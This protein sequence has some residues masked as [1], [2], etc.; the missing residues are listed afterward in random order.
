MPQLFLRRQFLI[1]FLITFIVFGFLLNFFAA[2]TA[3]WQIFLLSNLRGKMV[4]LINTILA[5]FGIGRSLPDFLFLT[6]IT[7]IQ[8]VLVGLLFFILSFRKQNLADNLQSTGIIASFFLLS[9]GCPTCGTALLTPVFLSILGSSGLALAGTI[10][11]VLNCLSIILALFVFQKIGY[12]A[13]II[14]ADQKYRAKQSIQD[15]SKEKKDAAIK[16]PK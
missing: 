9:S 5:V 6:I 2:G 1:P 10:S 8:S 16:D 11:V 15:S 13:Y 12:E 4:L 14:L 7:L 3:N